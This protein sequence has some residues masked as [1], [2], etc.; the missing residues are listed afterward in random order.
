[1]VVH[2]LSIKTHLFYDFRT[3]HSRTSYFFILYRYHNSNLSQL[4]LA[5]RR[6]GGQALTS[7]GTGEKN[8]RCAAPPALLFKRKRSA[9]G[10][11][12]NRCNTDIPYTLFLRAVATGSTPSLGLF[13]RGIPGVNLRSTC[14][15]SHYL[16]LSRRVPRIRQPYA[17]TDTAI[18]HLTQHYFARSNH[19]VPF[20]SPCQ[21]PSLSCTR[22]TRPNP[23]SPTMESFQSRK[24]WKALDCVALYLRVNSRAQDSYVNS[25]KISIETLLLSRTAGACYSRSTGFLM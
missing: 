20:F 18:R 11:Y 22:P 15:Y 4:Y 24:N 3:S 12:S 10:R 25:S 6:S 17:D 1:M 8:E 14:T 19:R 5:S 23:A 16:S 9:F 21:Y 2:L 13:L 7:L